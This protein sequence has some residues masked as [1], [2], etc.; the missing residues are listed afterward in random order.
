MLLLRQ[1]KGSRNL[2]EQ[3]TYF[4]DSNADDGDVD[5]GVMAERIA[6]H[7]GLL[8]PRLVRQ[9]PEHRLDLTVGEAD[10]R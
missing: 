9:A 2:L 3:R 8:L 10:K 1:N 4:C 5:G 7:E 6:D